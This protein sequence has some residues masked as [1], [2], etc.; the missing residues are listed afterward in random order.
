MKFHLRVYDN[1]HYGNEN[2]AYNSGEFSTYE[3]AI[4][5]AKAMIDESLDNK[6]KPGMSSKELIAKF[7]INGIEPA[8]LPNLHENNIRFSART[9]AEEAAEKICKIHENEK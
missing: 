5:E 7:N 2:E 9:Y 3:D 1:F 8:I 4:I 6:W